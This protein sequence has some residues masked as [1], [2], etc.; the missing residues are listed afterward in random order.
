MDHGAATLLHSRAGH[1]ASIG[2]NTLPLH[3]QALVTELRPARDAQ[4]HG[5]LLRLLEIGFLPG[6]AVRVVA[7]GGVGGDPIAVRVGQ[8][9]FALRHQEAS[10]V[11]VVPAALAER[12]AA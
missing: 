2:M 5:V 12:E 11:Q 6:E 4:E 3:A 8:V 1:P 9:T 7:R 10:M